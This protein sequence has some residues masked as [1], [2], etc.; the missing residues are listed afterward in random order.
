MVSGRA[1]R[2]TVGAEGVDG[3]KSAY[4]VYLDATQVR[5]IGGVG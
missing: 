3:G 5:L 1:W 4:V 2:G